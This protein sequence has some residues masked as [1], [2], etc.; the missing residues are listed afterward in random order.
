[1]RSLC[2]AQHYP[3]MPHEGDTLP[4]PPTTS[5]VPQSALPPSSFPPPP[6]GAT[7]PYPGASA[8]QAPGGYAYP[9]AGPA[10]YGYPA[11]STHDGNPYNAYHT[12][13]PPSAHYT[14]PSQ[15]AYNNA[16]GRSTLRTLLFTARTV[17]GQPALLDGPMHT[18]N[19]LSSSEGFV[20][21]CLYM[22]VC[23]C[24]WRWSSG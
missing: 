5:T 3:A 22:Y 9:P 16:W 17:L 10:P 19:M 14:M 23:V 8:V 4:P 12:G 18:V 24:S 11:S 2:D 13:K 15:A 21:R 6:P 1:M 20:Y 7:G